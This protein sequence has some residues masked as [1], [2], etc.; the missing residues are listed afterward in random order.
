MLWY[1]RSS[2]ANQIKYHVTS[3]HHIVS[4]DMKSVNQLEITFPCRNKKYQSQIDT[5]IQHLFDPVK[6][7][8][9]KSVIAS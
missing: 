6:N 8:V 1:E 3:L 5:E 9:N 7:N 4:H 2:K